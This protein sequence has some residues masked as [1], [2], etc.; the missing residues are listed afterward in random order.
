VLV[1]INPIL[2]SYGSLAVRWFGALALVGLALAICLSVRELGLQPSTRRA[3]VDA[4]AWGLPAGLLGARLV[5]VVGYWDYYLT[6]SGEIWQLNVEGLSMW[7]GLVVGGLV[8]G[9]RL[10]QDAI[11]RRHI[12]DII[13]PYA[14][15]GIAIG[16]VGEFLDG[17]G[18]GLA[19]AV[20]W[21]TQ[22]ASPLAATPD[23]GVARHPAQ[24]YDALLAL[25]LFA[26][27]KLLPNFAPT[28]ARLA[29]F[30]VI[31]GLGRVV[32]GQVR[33]DPAFLFGL[34]IEELLALGAVA[35]GG[36]YGL[37]L[38]LRTSVIRRADFGAK[39]TREARPAEETLPA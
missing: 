33:L 9:T 38:L 2:V 19:S 20:P 13:V 27:T 8:A 11:R 29:A 39:K 22:Y 17:H 35:F 18:Q 7:G 15:L 10:R 31:Y 3:A 5:H 6:N 37:R 4:L 1:D 26:L 28:G 21:A 25:G 12:L 36:V 23:F 24:M 30:L 16:R 32:I 14:A 34:Q